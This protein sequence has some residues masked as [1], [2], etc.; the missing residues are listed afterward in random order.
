MVTVT[1]PLPMPSILTPQ[2][3]EYKVVRRSAHHSKPVDEKAFL[4]GEGADNWMLC[5]VR[6]QRIGGA[7]W[8]YFMR[9]A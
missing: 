7:M 4:D 9:P 6:P 2:A 3:W 5:E 1:A 8:Y